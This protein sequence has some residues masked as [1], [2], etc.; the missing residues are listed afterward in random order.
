MIK[1]SSK[2]RL[3]EALKTILINLFIAKQLGKP[4]RYSRDRSWYT[5]DS[6]YGMLFFKYDRIIPII[7]AMEDL[8]FIEQKEGFFI[9][10]GD[11]A[12]RPDVGHR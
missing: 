9:R 12:D 10:D 11:H 2:S 4:V 6:K 1:V 8:G 5:R 7:D 3:K